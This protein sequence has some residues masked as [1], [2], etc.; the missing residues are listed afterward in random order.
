MIE[1]VWQHLKLL[2]T[3]FCLS[4]LHSALLLIHACWMCSDVV[5]VLMMFMRVL[6]QCFMTPAAD[7]PVTP[8]TISTGVRQHSDMTVVPT[9]LIHVYMPNLVCP[10]VRPVWPNQSLDPATDFQSR[11][12]LPRWLSKS[13]QTATSK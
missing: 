5:F 10:S 8:P 11:S 4:C 12:L 2:S 1:K 3:C 13:L 7:L 6:D 9:C